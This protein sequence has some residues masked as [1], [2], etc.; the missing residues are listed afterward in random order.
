MLKCDD[1]PVTRME[2]LA[3]VNK[4]LKDRNDELEFCLLYR[5]ERGRTRKR[6]RR[7]SRWELRL[8]TKTSTSNLDLF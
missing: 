8:L 1:F 3:R 2:E 4:N 5:A 6:G 7:T